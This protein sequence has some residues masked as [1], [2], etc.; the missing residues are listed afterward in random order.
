MIHVRW[1]L[2]E[3]ICSWSFHPLIFLLMWQRLWTLF[4]TSL[5]LIL[6]LRVSGAVHPLYHMPSLYAH[7][8]L[9][10]YP[11]SFSDVILHHCFSSHVRSKF[12]CLRITC[13]CFVVFDSPLAYLDPISCNMTYMFVQLFKDALNEYAYAAELAG[14]K[15]ELTNT[16]YGMIVSTLV[17]RNTLGWCCDWV[18]QLRIFLPCILSSFC[19]PSRHFHY[20]V[21]ILM[22]KLICL[23]FQSSFQIS[24]HLLPVF[25]TIFLLICL[26]MCWG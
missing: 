2:V 3:G 8:Q 20:N 17:T 10:L 22:M 1:A 19:L 16:K 21:H 15:W 13:M 4:I 23:A 9:Y 14:M 25:H 24:C 11:L 26:F 7:G 12:T 18:W 6:R 5:H